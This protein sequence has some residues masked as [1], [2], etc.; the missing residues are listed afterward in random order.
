[1]KKKVPTK[2]VF[3]LYRG[4]PSLEMGIE[5]DDIDLTWKDTWEIFYGRNEDDIADI[6]LYVCKAGAY[7]DVEQLSQLLP[8]EV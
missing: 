5:F 8:L 3:T 2:S 7:D 1:M 6:W 4:G